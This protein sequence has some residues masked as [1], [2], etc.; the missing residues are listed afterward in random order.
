MK[1]SKLIFVFLVLA[2][3]QAYAGP[4]CLNDRYQP[5]W[6]AEALAEQLQSLQERAQAA[7]PLWARLQGE[8]LLIKEDTLLILPENQS[9]Y[10][11][12]KMTVR[13]NAMIF[14]AQNARLVVSEVMKSS[15][16]QLMDVAA[17]NLS[18]EI[19][20]NHQL[21]SLSELKNNP[22]QAEPFKKCSLMSCASVAAANGG[23]GGAG[24]NGRDAG[25][26]IKWGI[27]K[28]TPS[29]DGGAGSAGGAGANGRNGDNG[30]QGVAGLNAHKLF[31]QLENVDLCSGVEI[32][33][34]GGAGLAGL[35]GLNAQD[36]GQGGSGGKGGRGGGAKWDRKASRGG[37]G[38]DGGAGG[39]GGHGGF[40]G[41]GGKGGD[42]GLVVIV[43]KPRFLDMVK[44][45]DN[46]NVLVAG[47]KGGPGGAQG[48]AGKGGRGGLAGEGGNGG[49]GSVFSHGGNSGLA[50][51]A[52]K[53]GLDGKD[54]QEG[55]PGVEGR[56]GLVTRAEIYISNDISIESFQF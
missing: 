39:N 18:A 44:V 7:K 50:G 8:D 49:D 11:I 23:H 32:V 36:G 37:R 54:G 27:P 24:G 55:R 14:Y 21:V 31:M 1:F 29:S 22:D 12:G 51:S 10:R 15:R 25:G 26:K 17:L 20:R 35:K 46:I 5:K 42:G 2:Q 45:N 13:N 34:A 48:L 4:L 16:V 40:G 30:A 19:D 47:G 53:Q 56:E 3:T 43:V 28:S 52:G 41:D 6:T 9:Q 33:A 38:G